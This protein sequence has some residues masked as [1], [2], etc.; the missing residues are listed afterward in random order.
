MQNCI[1]ITKLQEVSLG[2][3]ASERSSIRRKARVIQYT[4]T[5][6]E[7]FFLCKTKPRLLSKKLKIA[8]Q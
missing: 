5:E 4:A 2:V 6:E 3:K 7:N 8:R 1:Y